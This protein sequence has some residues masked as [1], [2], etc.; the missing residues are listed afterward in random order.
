MAGQRNSKATAPRVQAVLR[1]LE[2]G[3]TRRAAA[4]VAD[5]HPSTLYEWLAKD[6]TFSDA[7]EKAEAK[8]EGTY[9]AAVANAVPKSWQA[10]AW[11][12]ERRHHEDFAQRNKV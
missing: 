8:A 7:V 5:I 12:L 6:P 10:A 1:A 2:L 4:G 11:W 3:C 9:I